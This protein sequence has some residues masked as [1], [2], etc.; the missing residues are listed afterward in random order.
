MFYS[1]S[2]N[3][4]YSYDING[5]NIPS[6]AVEITYEQHAEL[7]AE[8]ANGKVIVANEDGFPI[9]VSPEP[10]VLTLEERKAINDKNREEAYR[11]EA[12]PIFFKAQRGEATNEE[13]LAKVEEIRTRYP[14]PTE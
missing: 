8:Q 4:F 2:N 9:A 1:P 7:M 14:E 12:D 3:G 11:N 13:W 6:D 5:T 10:A